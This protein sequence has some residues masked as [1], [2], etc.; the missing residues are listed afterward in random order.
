MRGTALLQSGRGSTALVGFAGSI[1]HPCSW[2]RGWGRPASRFHPVLTR[3]PKSDLPTR[4]LPS[5]SLSSLLR[6]LR[7]Q[8]RHVAGACCG[9]RQDP[10]GRG[11]EGA[12]GMVA[13]QHD[14]NRKVCFASP[15]IRRPQQ[16]RRP[17]LATDPS[18]AQAG[19][20]PAGNSLPDQEAK[21]ALLPARSR[22][23]SLPGSVPPQIHFSKLSLQ[24]CWAGQRGCRTQC[25]VTGASKGTGAWLHPSL[26]S[27]A[28]REP[29]LL[30]QRGVRCFMAPREGPGSACGNG[31][32]GG[33][34]EAAG[35]TDRARG[36]C[37]GGSTPQCQREQHQAHSQE[38]FHWHPCRIKFILAH[39]FCC[40]Q[41]S[42]VSPK[43]AQ[44]LWKFGAVPDG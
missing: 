41:F 1:E 36:Y 21:P 42:K 8:L 31:D 15:G 33:C 23:A 3:V 19:E 32:E 5:L 26:V 16:L 24:R 38:R 9:V 14:R 6:G 27:P 34:S 43:R 28:L 13:A 20:K 25:E 39:F 22:R 2:K 18:G 17:H 37:L 11:A 29:V 44:L 12:A 30:A 4:L 40:C 35:R 10:A 7:A